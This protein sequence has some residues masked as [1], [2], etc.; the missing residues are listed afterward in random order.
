MPVI[1]SRD[2][3]RSANGT[4]GVMTNSTLPLRCKRRNRPKPRRRI[5]IEGAAVQLVRSRLGDERHLAHSSDVGAVVGH[6]DTHLLK[7]F[8]ELQK[9]S[10]LC[11]VLPGTDADAIDGLVRLVSPTSRKSTK[12]FTTASCN[13]ARR[14]R[15]KVV[16]R[17]SIQW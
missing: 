2:N 3:N 4:S 16:K 11:A 15:Q 10:N 7:T 13:D 12:R 17:P 1:D 9:R 5:I 8:D 6:I 14:K